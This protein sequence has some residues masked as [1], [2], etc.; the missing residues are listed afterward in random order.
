MTQQLHS[1]DGSLCLFAQ[2]VSPLWGRQMSESMFTMNKR[3]I[4]TTL[5]KP[6]WKIKWSQTLAR[7]LSH[8]IFSLLRKSAEIACS[9]EIYKLKTQPIGEISHR[10]STWMNEGMGIAQ[11]HYCL[12]HFNGVCIGAILD[13]AYAYY[14]IE[15]T[16]SKALLFLPGC[17]SILWEA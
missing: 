8:R 5:I 9:W 16:V 17:Q 11:E 4:K 1:N 14:T 2:S 13:C 15:I 6:W 3:D 12:I 7:F 10:T